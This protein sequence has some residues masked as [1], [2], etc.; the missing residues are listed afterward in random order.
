MV[1]KTICSSSSNNKNKNVKMS[2]D[3]DTFPIFKSRFS[4]VFLLGLHCKSICAVLE[5]RHLCGKFVFVQKKVASTEMSLGNVTFYCWD[6]LEFYMCK[7][8]YNP[9]SGYMHK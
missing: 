1:G 8:L 9:I 4:Y 3:C 5:V 2:C 6:Y 7:V